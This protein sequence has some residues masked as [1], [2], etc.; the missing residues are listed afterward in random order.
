[1][2]LD[3]VRALER[4]TQGERIELIC[5]WLEELGISYSFHDYVSGRNIATAVDERPVIAVA[6]H[7]DVVAGSPGANDNGSATAVC[8]EILRRS[9]TE[10]LESHA[11]RAFFFDQEEQGL[12][13]SLAY[14]NEFGPGQLR[15]LFNM[16][17]VGAGDRFALWPLSAESRGQ[18]LEAFE[19]SA[20]ALGVRSHRFDR[21][22]TNAADH[23][24]FWQQGF[25]ETFT[26]T[27]ISEEDVNVASEYYRA[28]ARGQDRDALRRILHGAPLF[29]HYHQPSDDS[30]HLSESTLRMCADA[31]WHAARRLDEGGTRTQPSS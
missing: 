17:L 22:I 21:I 25:S 31:I 5:S 7:H 13:G 20:A 12:A 19:A 14:A 30:S 15:A 9:V 26:I 8:F 4:S 11:V 2:L 16:E 27:C 23:Q 3:Y 6:T 24:S 18:A 1:M 29:R 10:P 28:M